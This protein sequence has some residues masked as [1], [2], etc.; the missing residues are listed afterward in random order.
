MLELEQFLLE[1]E[2][3]LRLRFV[4]SGGGCGGGGCFGL[5]GRGIRGQW[6]LSR[7]SGVKGQK[8]WLLLLKHLILLLLLLI[9]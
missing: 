8:E 2:L 1:F 4:G 7:L 9:L 3:Y 5:N 6:R